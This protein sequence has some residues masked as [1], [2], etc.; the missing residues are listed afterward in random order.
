MKILITGGAGFIGSNLAAY[1]AR[2][3]HQVTIFDNFSRRGSQANLAW[4]KSLPESRGAVMARA[5]R[6]AGGADYYNRQIGTDR[7][8]S[9]SLAAELGL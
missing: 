6:R 2:Q 3:G 4:L 8:V 9:R 5:I 7:I 1:F